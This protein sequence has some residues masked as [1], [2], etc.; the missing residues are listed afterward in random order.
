MFS[1]MG[2]RCLGTREVIGKEA[3]SR[4]NCVEIDKDGDEIYSTYQSKGLSGTHTF[5][6]GT[7]KYAGLS[8]TADYTVQPVKSPDARGM[9]IVRHKATWQRP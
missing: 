5:V 4:G 9:A 1:D 7:G 6:G 2:A 3:V 8:G